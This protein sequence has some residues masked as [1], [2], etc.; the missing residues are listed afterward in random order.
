MT[1]LAV[2]IALGVVLWVLV[3]KS[4]VHATLAGVLLAMTIPIRLTPGKP[5]ATDDV[6]PLHSTRCKSRWRFLSCRSS[7]LQT[8]AS[9]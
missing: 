3:L 8:R 2:Y 9:P 6:S 5:E 4:G 1:V 7:G